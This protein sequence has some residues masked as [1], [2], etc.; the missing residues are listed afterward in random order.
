[1]SSGTTEGQQMPP[2]HWGSVLG[3]VGEVMR[4]LY[5]VLSASPI[6]RYVPQLQERWEPIREKSR[7]EEQ[8]KSKARKV[9]L[10]GK[11]D[12]VQGFSLKK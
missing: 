8:A 6:L 9:H 7:A 12:K 1:M 2:H 5:S 10:Q 4:L 11:M 3:D